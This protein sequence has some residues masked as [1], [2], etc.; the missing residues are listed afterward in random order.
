M[1]KIFGLLLVAAAIGW[2][3]WSYLPG[4]PT[5]QI[6][7]G[8]GATP[9]FQVGIVFVALVFVGIHLLFVG[10]VFRYPSWVPRRPTA[11]GQVRGGAVD[12]SRDDIRISRWMELFWTAFPIGVMLAVFVLSYLSVS[13]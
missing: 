13:G 10:A 7:F 3:V 11:L 4:A 1:R 2:L 5:W 8:P 9:F 12:Q 6:A